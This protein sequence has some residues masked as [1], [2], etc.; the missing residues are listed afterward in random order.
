MGVK[1]LHCGDD[2]LTLAVSGHRPTETFHV[3]S[4]PHAGGGHE[5]GVVR[6]R[7]QVKSHRQGIP[8]LTLPVGQTAQGL[9]IGIELDGP[10]KSDRRLLSIGLALEEIFS[11][12]S[13]TAL[14]TGEQK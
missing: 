14:Q 8:G 3:H 5:H 12:L 2:H 11:S 9:P 4:K 1:Q 10:I 13:V 7:H 6:R